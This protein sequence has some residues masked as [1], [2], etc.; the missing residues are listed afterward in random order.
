MS[1]RPTSGGRPRNFSPCGLCLSQG[2]TILVDRPARVFTYFNIAHVPIVEGLIVP[3][4]EVD[5][6]PLGTLWVT[7]HS[8]DV[9]GF[10]STD[11]RVIERLAS[12]LLLS[13]KLQRLNL[14]IRAVTA[15]AS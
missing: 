13:M 2:S 15:S 14:R 12:Q 5:G 7:S 10:D 11:A 9:R 3:L 4:Y 8:E 1:L 6:E